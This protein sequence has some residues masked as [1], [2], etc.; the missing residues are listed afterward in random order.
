MTYLT[1]NV[2]FTKKTPTRLLSPL[3]MNNTPV[4]CT[5][6]LLFCTEFHS[7]RCYNAHPTLVF[8]ARGFIFSSLGSINGTERKTDS[9][10]YTK[11]TID[12]N[13]SRTGLTSIRNFS[14]KFTNTAIVFLSYI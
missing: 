13:G 11:T 10:Y 6:A 4:H 14:L 1:Q 12:C 8:L 2:R 3:L 7:R 9:K 5:E